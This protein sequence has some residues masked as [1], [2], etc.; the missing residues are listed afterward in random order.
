LDVELKQL[1]L[2][3]STDPDD[4]F[5]LALSLTRWISRFPSPSRLL[6]QRMKSRRKHWAIVRYQAGN[7][8][9]RSGRMSGHVGALFL[10]GIAM[11]DANAVKETGQLVNGKGLDNTV[12]AASW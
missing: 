6:L 3:I 8:P 7:P 11:G 1:A 5:D 10:L 9:Q 4:E 12:F 2:E